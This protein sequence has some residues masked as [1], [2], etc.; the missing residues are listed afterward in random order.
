[1]NVAI[2]LAAAC[3]LLTGCSGPQSALNP[4]G[5]QASNISHLWWVYFTVTAVVYVLTMLF[6]LLSV[7]PRQPRSTNLEPITT[8]DPHR[9]GR[10]LVVIGSAIGVTTVILFVLLFAD[11]FTT[12]ALGSLSSVG[13]NALSIKIIG[14]Q[15]WWEVQY[16]DPVPS[17]YVTTAN[18]LHLPVGKP[19]MVQLA[20]SDVIH[21]FWVPN[22]HGKKDLI[23]GHP[24]TNW[25]RA[26][27]VGNFRG[28]CAEF[29]GYQHAQMRLAVTV[30]PEDKFNEW[31]T[32]QK[33]EAPQPQTDIQ[34]RGQDVFL[35]TTCVMCHTIQ[36]TPAFGRIGPDLTHIASRPWLGAGARPNNPATRAAW[37]QNSQH[38]KPGVHMPQHN[39]PA[40]EL[41]ALLNYLDILK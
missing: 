21:S 34:K 32:A 30:D 29:C 28:Q 25:L 8:P 4:A 19:V 38:I 31:L 39:L 41:Q 36:G 13:T 24:T 14:H 27:R 33:Q 12:R 10:V 40:E 35:S 5:S 22:L 1:M 17:N 3:L 9:E 23:P 26:T 7:R 6:L 2:F 20:S 18:E 11:L 16:T 15:W 37:I